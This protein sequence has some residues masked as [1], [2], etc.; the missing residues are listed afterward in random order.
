[1]LWA[2]TGEEAIVRDK[3]GHNGQYWREL[4]RDWFLECVS[5]GF[6][7][8]KSMLFIHVSGRLVIADFLRGTL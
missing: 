6:G 5:V 4:E 8:D 3:I 2:G 7:I 1:M